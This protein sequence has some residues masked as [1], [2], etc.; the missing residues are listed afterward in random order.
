MQTKEPG[1]FNIKLSMCE[2]GAANQPNTDLLECLPL[3]CKYHIQLSMC[4]ITRLASVHCHGKSWADWK[5]TASQLKSKLLHILGVERY[6]GDE[7][8]PAPFLRVLVS[9]LAV[10][11]LEIEIT[12]LALY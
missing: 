7:H 4:T 12:L 3:Q 2:A 8:V 5:L 6:S 9:Y 1:S 11:H 10:H